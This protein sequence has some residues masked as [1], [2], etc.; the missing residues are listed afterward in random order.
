MKEDLHKKYSNIFFIIWGIGVLIFFFK[1]EIFIYFFAFI[2]FIILVL[3]IKKFWSE[4]FDFLKRVKKKIKALILIIRKIRKK[5]SD[6][7]EKVRKVW[8]KFW[9]GVIYVK[10]TMK[11]VFLL[12]GKILY[13]IYKGRLLFFIALS[14]EY[15]IIGSLLIYFFVFIPWCVK[16]RKRRKNNVGT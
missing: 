4:I 5:I 1:R 8:K 2:F 16:L 7:F 10:T 14:I 13:W 3:M 15:K 6:F 9:S 11:N 12:L